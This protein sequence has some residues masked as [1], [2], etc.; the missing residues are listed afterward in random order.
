[1]SNIKKALLWIY[2]L[3][4]F[5]IM[6][7]FFGAFV[8][9]EQSVWVWE[10]YKRDYIRHGQSDAVLVIYLYIIYYSFYVVAPYFIL[11]IVYNK[12]SD[13]NNEGFC[14]NK[15]IISAWCLASYLIFSE[16]IIQF[17]R[18]IPY[19]VWNGWLLMLYLAFSAFTVLL[20]ISIEKKRR[21]KQGGV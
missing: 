9:N 5:L 6:P 16:S 2:G 10:Q 4:L 14:F 19:E 18:N 11:S 1:M 17:I 12:T 15:L 8:R 21:L 3:H 7:W 13:I 20:F